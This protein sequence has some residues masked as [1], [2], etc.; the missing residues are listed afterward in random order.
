MDIIMPIADH[1][2]LQYDRLKSICSFRVE[3][4]VSGVCRIRG[5]PAA[6]LWRGLSTGA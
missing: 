6:S 2:A 5:P 4:L 1:T 3:R